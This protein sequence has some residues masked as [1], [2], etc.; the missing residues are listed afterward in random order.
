MSPWDLLGLE[1]GAERAAIRRAYADRLRAMDPEADPHAFQRLRGARDAAL[2]GEERAFPEEAP[3]QPPSSPRSEP[4]T[5]TRD[6]TPPPPAEMVPTIEPDMAA[7]DRLRDL[8][9]DPGADPSSDEIVELADRILADPA[10]L[11]V[12]HAMAVESYFADLIVHGTPRSDPLIDPAIRYFRW[13]RTEDDLGGAPVIDWI[14]R[15]ESDRYFDVELATHHPSWKKLLDEL[16][17][18]PPTRWPR[19]RSWH[20]GHRVEYLL[21]YIQERHPTTMATLNREAVDW[22]TTRIEGRQSYPA[23]IR[24]VDRQWRNGV[25][26]KGFGLSRFDPGPLGQNLPLYI[27]VFMMP[28]VFAWF[29]LRRRHG[30]KARALGFGWLLLTVG[31]PLLIGDPERG[32]VVQQGPAWSGVPPL[33]PSIDPS[34]SFDPSVLGAP[35]GG[36]MTGAPVPAND[37]TMRPDVPVHTRDRGGSPGAGV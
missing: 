25:F 26:A 36:T 17:T 2:A 3:P 35:P 27:G 31:A 9:M 22:W 1:P 24:P 15:R 8:V 37:R 29:L 23:I 32:P 10:M 21:A 11:N 13:D 19:L 14:L 7:I 33:D 34:G 5:A 28:Y 12:Q 20:K 16:R 6:P 18:G 4:V 30:W